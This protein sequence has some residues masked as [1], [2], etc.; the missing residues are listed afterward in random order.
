MNKFIGWTQSF[1]CFFFM[2]HG[3]LKKPVCKL[4][5]STRFSDLA[6]SPQTARDVWKRQR[7]PMTHTILSTNLLW[8][9]TLTM[10]ITLKLL[11]VAHS[12]FETMAL[13]IQPSLLRLLWLK[14]I[15]DS[16]F[17]GVERHMDEKITSVWQ[18]V[19]QLK[20]S[21]FPVL[22]CSCCVSCPA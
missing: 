14:A 11:W 9:N 10:V 13:Q 2:Q 20:L 21:K 1:V 7:T 22:F 8:M 17:S 12:L 16:W 19:G 4:T 18:Y 3:I 6:N 15:G 5:L